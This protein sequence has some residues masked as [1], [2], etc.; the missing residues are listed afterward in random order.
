MTDEEA[1]KIGM[2][3]VGEVDDREDDL[4]AAIGRLLDERDAAVAL[5]RDVRQIAL[6]GRSQ[7]GASDE[8]LEAQL[9]KL[10]EAGEFLARDLNDKD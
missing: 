2:N 8:V 9:A 1:N 4:Y 6:D 5:L 10:H 7:F 3:F